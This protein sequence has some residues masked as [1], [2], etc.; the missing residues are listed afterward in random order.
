MS[1]K[2]RDRKPIRWH[3]GQIEIKAFRPFE[4]GSN[5]IADKANFFKDIRYSNQSNGTK[6]NSDP[7]YDPAQRS[8]IGRYQS[9]ETYNENLSIYKGDKVGNQ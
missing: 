1:L 8:K 3:P 4:E 9:V 7:L 2:K 6:K 5:H